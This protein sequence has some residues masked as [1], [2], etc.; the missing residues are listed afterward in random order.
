MM[1]MLMVMVVV[2]SGGGSSDYLRF[3][4]DLNDWFDVAAATSNV[5]FL[6]EG[7]PQLIVGP[8]SA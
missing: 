2:V 6:L 4:E 8:L 7:Q 3:R 5:L 1:M